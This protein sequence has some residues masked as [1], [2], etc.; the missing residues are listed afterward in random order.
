MRSVA[1][2]PQNRQ[3]ALRAMSAEPLDILVVGAG[4]VGAGIALDA[5]TRGLSVGLVEA[6]D[7]ASGTPPRHGGPRGGPGGG[8]CLAAGPREPVEQ[9]DSRWPAVPRDARLPARR[10]G[11]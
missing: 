7:F 1:L 9:A 11:I 6:R 3:A 10:G 2:S 4:V 5:A 8:P